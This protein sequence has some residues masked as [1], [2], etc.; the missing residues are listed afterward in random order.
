MV[1][2]N[3]T[4]VIVTANSVTGMLSIFQSAA[5]GLRLAVTI[6]P[7]APTITNMKYI[8]QKIGWRMH[9]GRRVVA[10]G[11]DDV[12]VLGDGGD[13]AGLRREQEEGE[14][15]DDDALSETEI[16]EG[17]LEAGILDHRL[18]RRDRQRG[19]RTKTCRG[20]AG[21]KAALV[22]KPFQRIADA[23]AVDAA[24]ADA[25]DDM[26]EIEAVQRG[27]L[28]VDRPADGTQN[29]TNQH[30][31]ARA[32]FVD[33]PALDRHQPGLEQHEQREGPLDR[34]A[35]PSEL[36]L[37]VR[38][39]ESPAILVVRD[40]HHGADADRQLR[41]AIGVADACLRWWAPLREPYLSSSSP[42]RCSI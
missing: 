32:V 40:H 39:E 15:H 18:D 13:L 37:D 8:S 24:G 20:D 42:K 17:G 3:V 29:A 21:G 41:P 33:E 36:L 22:G 35:I 14:D 10:P 11:L 16:E 31:D 23:G 34:G 26:A 6:N 7:P 9:F 38:D 25:R 12:G 2:A 27:G 1:A 28:G 4:A 19:A 5:I 30:H